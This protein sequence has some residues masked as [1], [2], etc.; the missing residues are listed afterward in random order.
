MLQFLYNSEGKADGVYLIKTSFD[1]FVNKVR[2]MSTGI[3]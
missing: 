3:N 1:Y 2:E